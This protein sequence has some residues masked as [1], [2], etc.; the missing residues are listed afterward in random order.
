MKTL[1]RRIL[2]E[3]ANS[4]LLIGF[5]WPRCRKFASVETGDEFEYAALVRVRQ[6]SGAA[7][8]ALE[9]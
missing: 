6:I 8:D 1:M 9:G 4:E 3:Y 2:K 5:V 7:S